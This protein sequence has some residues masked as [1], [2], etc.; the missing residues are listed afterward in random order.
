INTIAMAANAL[1]HSG[2][3]NHKDD[4]L[5]EMIQRSTLRMNRLIQDL[6]DTAV[7]ER[8]G[9]LPLNPKEHPA[10][11]LAE[12]VCEITRIQAKAKTVDVH[13]DI[14][15]NATV[16]VDRDRL[17]QVLTNL[18]DNAIKFTPEGGTVTVRSEVAQ[19]EV[20]FSVSDTGP[21][22]PESD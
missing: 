11:N 22:I 12:E 7:I 14:E 20:R 19:N 13:C 18:I 16:W 4:R 21:G 8:H 9:E 6:I 2:G 1:S 17:L 15:G 10:Q 3:L 5:V